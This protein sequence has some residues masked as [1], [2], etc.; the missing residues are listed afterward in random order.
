MVA[1]T[2]QAT[3]DLGNWQI[4]RET[5]ELPFLSLAI[6]PP[7]S[8]CMSGIDWYHCVVQCAALCEVPG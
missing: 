6:R 3:F 8:V 7:V 4:S 2:V 5:Y 1:D